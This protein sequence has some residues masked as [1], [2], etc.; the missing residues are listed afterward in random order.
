V[1]SSPDEKKRRPTNRPQKEKKKN[2]G[3]WEKREENLGFPLQSKGGGSHIALQR[4]GGDD[5]DFYQKGKKRNNSIER[6]TTKFV[7]E[8]SVLYG[9]IGKED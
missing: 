6:G 2:G 7:L 4:K 3:V 8:L 5:K 9:T 1:F